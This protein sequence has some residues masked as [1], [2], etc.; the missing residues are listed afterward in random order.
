MATEERATDA[1][2][3]A[4]REQEDQDA[5]RRAAHKDVADRC[6]S[7]ATIAATNLQHPGSIDATHSEVAC[8]LA[9]LHILIC[10][11]GDNLHHFQ[12]AVRK[13]LS[14]SCKQPGSAAKHGGSLCAAACRIYERL[15]AEKQAEDNARDERER[16]VDL[17]YQEQ[18][19]HC[20]DTTRCTYPAA[21]I[22]RSIVQFD[23]LALPAWFA[24]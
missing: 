2:N 12:G 3:A 15:K 24:C 5:A 23:G 10:L 16:M 14:P 13:R 19:C 11:C 8:Q 22:A 7:L 20:R 9:A 18:V 6:D 17:M 1:Y 21:S 4:K